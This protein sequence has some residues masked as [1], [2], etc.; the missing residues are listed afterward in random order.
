MGTSVERALDVLESISSSPKKAGALGEELGV[1]RSTMVRLLQTLDERGYVRRHP[2]GKWGIGF[3][4]IAVSQQAL[5]SMDLREIARPHLAK[6]SAAAGHTIHLAARE[7]A[8]VYYVDKVEGEGEVRMRSR[9][10]AEARLHTAGVAKVIMAFAPREIQ[11]QAIEACT[12]DRF[13]ST[14]IAGAD[15]LR[16][17][18]ALIK[19]R[20]WA[21]DDGEQE[22]WINCVAVP[23]FDATGDAIGGLSVTAVR[24]IATLDD[25]QAHLSA[26][27]AA[28]DSISQELG[29]SA[30]RSGRSGVSVT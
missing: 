5:D 15:E 17:E 18:W 11:D 8:A 2:S 20:G 12:F 13:T 21:T 6:L 1:H 10:G 23:V 4:L 9:V 19:R 24:S 16:R 29:W 14:T 25:L 28:R 30:P 26:I 3:R 22:D 27:L 7:G